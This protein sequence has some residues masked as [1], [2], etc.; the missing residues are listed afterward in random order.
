MRYLKS[1]NESV[2]IYNID[3]HKISPDYLTVIK[4]GRTTKFHCGNIMKHFDMVQVSYD[5]VPGEIWGVP[6]TLELDIYFVKPG[7]KIDK[8]LRLNID[9]TYGDLV[10]S[11]FSITTPNKVSV[12]EYTSYHSK[13]DPSNTVFAFYEESLEKLIK[14]FNE[15]NGIHVSREQFNFLDANPNNYY[16]S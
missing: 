11:E 6:D 9:I 12:I 1:F 4:D 16:P 14:F 5:T 3:W 8:S 15:F 2:D 7:G 13:F 10:A